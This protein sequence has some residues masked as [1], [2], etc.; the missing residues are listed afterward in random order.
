MEP[1]ALQGVAHRFYELATGVRVHVAEAGPLDAPVVV[2]L[3]GFPQH[4][5]MWRRVIALMAGEARILAM[6]LR[7]LGWSEQPADGDFRKARIADDAVALLDALGIERALLAG[8][9]WGAWAGFHAVLDA[10]SRWTAFV[11]TGIAHPWQPPGIALRLLPRLAY[12]P[13]LA[14]PILGPR[15]VRAGV[16]RILRGAWGDRST[17]DRRA[18]DLYAARYAEP[19]RAEA[20]SRY[21]RDFLLHEV[22]RFPGGRLRVPTRLLYGRRD[23]LGVAPAL[24]V[25]RHGEDA[26]T[27]LLDGCGHFVPE[28]RPAEVA[29]AIRGLLSRA[30]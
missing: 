22:L 12:Q 15:V 25:E 24:G 28:E 7:G 26:R 29:E 17:Y 21:Y 2:A 8:H 11:P 13:P 5:W 9:D 4:W 19:E 1:P 30:A 14:A 16:R 20:G 3:H 23:F 10:P 6:D 18:E 27:V